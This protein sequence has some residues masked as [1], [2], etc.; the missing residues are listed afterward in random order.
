M[1]ITGWNELFDQKTTDDMAE[2]SVHKF[3]NAASVAEV[4]RNTS[5]DELVAGESTY[6]PEKV[7]SVIDSLT[8]DDI[9]DGII[10]KLMT[11]SSVD[12]WLNT[13]TTR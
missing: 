9:Q 1:T 7:R 6:S 2:G 8:L 13:K 10:R 3:F 12:S 4:I 11:I 5:V